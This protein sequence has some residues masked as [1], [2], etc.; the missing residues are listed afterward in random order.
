MQDQKN[1]YF[2][3]AQEYKTQINV[4]ILG[5][6]RSQA[7]NFSEKVKLI[8]DVKYQISD[9]YWGMVGAWINLKDHEGKFWG[10]N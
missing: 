3:P 9:C 4:I 5:I 7:Y 6:L 2:L 10:D 8:N 1:T